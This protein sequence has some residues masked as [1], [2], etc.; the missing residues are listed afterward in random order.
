MLCERDIERFLHI[1]QDPFESGICRAGLF[2]AI[3]IYLQI[4]GVIEVGQR[5]GQG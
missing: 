2:D 4:D 5:D 1:R 3:D